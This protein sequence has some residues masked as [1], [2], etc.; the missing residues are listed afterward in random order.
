MRIAL[1]GLMA[2]AITLAVPTDTKTAFSQVETSN[3]LN[4]ETEADTG[5]LTISDADLET[6]AYA[7]VYA[8]TGS[9]ALVVNQV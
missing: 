7:L 3:E 4:V 5:L 8:E 6:Y 2:A 9:E 1:W